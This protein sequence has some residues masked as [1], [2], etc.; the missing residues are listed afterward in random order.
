MFSKN[1]YGAGKEYCTYDKH[2]NAPYLRRTFELDKIPETAS[3]KI[4]SSGF[5]EL[6]IN[7]EKITKCPLSPYITNPDSVLVYDTYDLIPYLKSGENCIGIILGNGLVNCLGGFI[8]DFE[9]APY[10]AAPSAAF[11]FEAKNGDKT[12]LSFEADENIKTHPSPILFDDLRSGV[13]YDARLEIPDWCK[14]G[15]DDKDWTPAIKA[16]TL[17]GEPVDFD[18]DKLSFSEILDAVSFEQGK[19]Q[20]I[21]VS[22]HKRP[23]P[24][25]VHVMENDKQG[26]VYDFGKNSAGVPI[27]KIKGKPGQ[28]IALQFSEYFRGGV[29]SYENT[30]TFYPDGY[31][32]RD[33]YICRGDGSEETFMPPFTYHGAQYCTVIGAEKEQ[34]DIDTVKFCVI[35]SDFVSR[36]DFDCSDRIASELQK[37]VRRSDLANF[38]YFPT[39]CPHR[40]K[41]GWTGDASMS[42]EQFTLNF[43]VEKSLK[44]WMRLIRQSQRID[45]AIAGIV[46]TSGWGYAWGNGPIWDSVI[47]ELPYQT[48]KY[49][50]DISMFKEN[51]DMVLR[52]L[53][54]AAKKR[55]TRGLCAFGLTDW[56][57]PG[58]DSANPTTPQVVTDT[59]MLVNICRKAGIMF[60]AAGLK[61]ESDYAYSLMNEYRNAAREYLVDLNT[62]TALG[63]T[64][65]A[66]SAAIY[67]EIFDKAEIPEAGRRLVEIVHRANDVF[68][69]G[70]L[71]VRLVFNVLAD[72][73]YADLAYKM[74]TRS[75]VRGYGIWIEKFGISTL[76]E[77]FEDTIDGFTTSLDHHFLGDISDFF[78]T[79]IAGIRVNPKL[80]DANYVEI[81]PNFVKTLDSACTHYDTVSGK[82][83]VSWKRSPD[84]TVSVSVDKPCAVRV[85]LFLPKGFVCT[86]PGFY[87]GKSALLNF[88]GVT[89]AKEYAL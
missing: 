23:M 72:L 77:S 53:H 10:R 36:G 33:Y 81:R 2:V 43:G 27:F 41:N 63:E 70:M 62:M 67:Y 26:Y 65:C 84:G 59:F 12:V 49:R 88:S 51:A 5:Y 45:G 19:E 15:F 22:D 11:Y 73:G 74:I 57:Q 75:D 9:K 48:Y 14:P 78:I 60:A 21:Q 25:S 54:Y 4:T 64:Q 46:P 17:R 39:D 50:G 37:A 28:M 80:D 38:V 82:V 34:L 86:T 85:N 58:Y 83:S 47:V 68:D 13:I 30:N 18:T 40:E 6:Y 76:P 32:Q 42:A 61:A 31:T 3:L 44:F 24:P 8:W 52:Y 1:F 66:Q 16:D 20:E 69:C 29:Y 55:N 71:G 7:G 56:V 87:R 79:K 35:H 89:E